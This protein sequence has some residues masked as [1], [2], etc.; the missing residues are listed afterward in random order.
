MRRNLVVSLSLSALLG[1]A[2]AT[3]LAWS[4]PKSSPGCPRDP[5]KDGSPCKRKHATCHWPCEAEGDSNLTCSC[6]KDESGA[7]RWQCASMGPTCI[8]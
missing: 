3:T 1:V 7:W 2:L 4:R 5:V 6:E 8:L